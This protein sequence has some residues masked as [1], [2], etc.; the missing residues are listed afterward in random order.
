MKVYRVA[1]EGAAPEPWPHCLRGDIAE[2]FSLVV[3]EGGSVEELAACVES[4]EVVALYALHEGLHI[5]YI[6]PA[7]D[8][9]NEGFRELYPDGVPALTSLVAA[10]DGPPSEDPVGDIAV[11]RSWP[12]C[13]RGEIAEGFSLLVYQG[14]SVEDLVACAQSRNVTAL[15]ALHEGAYLSYILG[16]PE[17]VNSAFAELFAG[18]VPAVT[19]L[20]GKSSGPP[21]AGSA[22]SDEQN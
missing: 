1:L 19:P 6:L 22:R 5:P 4:R 12:H 9:V 20:V 16:A 3:Y 14:G 2:G 18:G 21:G 17:L 10:S 7:P 15:Y 13:L 8:F 11:P